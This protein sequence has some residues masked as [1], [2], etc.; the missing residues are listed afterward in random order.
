METNSETAENVYDLDEFVQEIF[1][2]TPD[3]AINTDAAVEDFRTYIEKYSDEEL[4]NILN[5]AGYIPDLYPADSSQETLYTKLCE[6]MEVAWAKRMGFES[7]EVTQKA[8]YE[9]VVIKINDSVIVSDTKTFR[10]SRSQ[11]APNVK[12][13]VKPEDYA[14]WI[15]RHQGKRLGGLVVYPQLH[16][17]QNRSDAYAYCS[18]KKNPIVMLPFHYLGFLLSQ[19]ISGNLEPNSLIGLWNYELLFPETVHKRSDYWKIINSA[20]LQICNVTQDEFTKYMKQAEVAMRE[21]V[22]LQSSKLIEVIQLRISAIKKESQSMSET[23]LRDAYEAYKIAAETST[24]REY[25]DRIQRF[26]LA[27]ENTVY[28]KYLQM[29]D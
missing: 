28:F 19:K 20:L 1:K 15:A 23:E 3:G 14:K 9:D 21:Y 16:E 10:L 27:G 11:A 2:Q 4:A 5:V 6:V 24:L 12:D 29:G 7:V 26:R 8:S 25:V 17:W 13:F 18:N 22:S